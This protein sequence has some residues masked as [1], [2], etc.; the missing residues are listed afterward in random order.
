MYEG[1]HQLRTCVGG[2]VGIR[3]GGVCGVGKGSKGRGPARARGGPT[4]WSCAREKGA[5]G[6][7]GTWGGGG[8]GDEEAGGKAAD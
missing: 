4:S 1:G 2:K 8:G 5:R 6:R 3:G 7:D